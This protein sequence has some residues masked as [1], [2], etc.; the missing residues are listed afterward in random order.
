MKNIIQNGKVEMI[1]NHSKIDVIFKD[2]VPYAEIY[3]CWAAEIMEVQID[4]ESLETVEDYPYYISIDVFSI[5]TFSPATFR[6]YHKT[7]EEAEEDMQKFKVGED[8]FDDMEIKA[9]NGP[10][11]AE[12]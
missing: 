12:K 4:I 9:V 2:G 3:D 7:L 10:F 11:E 5:D 1:R 8:F 6:R